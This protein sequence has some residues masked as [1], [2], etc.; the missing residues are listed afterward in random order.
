MGVKATAAEAKAAGFKKVQP[1]RDRSKGKLIDNPKIGYLCY[2]GPCE[3][4]TGA[5]IV[6]YRTDTGCDDCWLQDDPHC[7]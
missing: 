1:P 6:C 5:R 2:E 4:G 3:P 7:S